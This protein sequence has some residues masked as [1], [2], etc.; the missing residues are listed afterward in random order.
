M[1]RKMWKE[2]IKETFIGFV[3]VMGILI[4]FLIGIYFL[5]KSIEN[6]KTITNEKNTYPKTMKVVDIQEDIVTVKDANG[7]IFQFEGAEDWMI[8]DFCSCIMDSKGT[9]EILDDEIIE[10]R[11]SGFFEESN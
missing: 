2:I 1:N 9:E 10:K 5:A 4:I 11:Y 3:R 8:G 7:F 6:E